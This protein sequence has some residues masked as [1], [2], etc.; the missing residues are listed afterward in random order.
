MADF[1]VIYGCESGEIMKTELERILDL[2]LEFTGTT[3]LSMKE[4][5][6]LVRNAGPSWLKSFGD[7]LASAIAIPKRFFM[8]EGK[9][10]AGGFALIP[11]F[12]FSDRRRCVIAV[13]H[14]IGFQS[15]S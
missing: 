8:A 3:F 13:T 4:R 15:H 11:W 5:G 12:R 9:D 1:P 14:G 7:P 2:Q 6:L 10:G